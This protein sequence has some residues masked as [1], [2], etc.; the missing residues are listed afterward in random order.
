VLVVDDDN[1]LLILLSIALPDV[2][3]VEASRV[4]EGVTLAERG[5]FDAVIVD[6]RLPDGDG[7]ELVQRLRRKGS[8]VPILVFTA[9][10][11]E[12]DRVGLMAAG[13]DEYLAKRDEIADLAGV[14]RRLDRLTVMTP[15]ELRMR[16]AELV[17]RLEAGEEGD[18]DPLPAAVPE[19]GADE[20][21]RR[22]LWRR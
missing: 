15:D 4:S 21:P 1:Y 22:R 6:R 20:R 2:E 14:R 5:D 8:D 10:H 3:M 16:R 9:G 18:L 13:A 12:A 7:L 19:S 17:R 11:T